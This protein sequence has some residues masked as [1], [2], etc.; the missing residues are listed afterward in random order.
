MNANLNVPLSSALFTVDSRDG[1]RTDPSTGFIVDAQN[2]Y[3][4]QIYKNQQLFSGAVQRI[5][6]TEINMPFNVPNVNPYNNVLY[7]E[8]G[9]GNEFALG[10]DV[11]TDELG[12]VVDTTIS[13]GFYTPQELAAQLQALLINSSA[14]GTNTWTVTYNASYGVPYNNPPGKPTFANIPFFTIN[15]NT[16]PF[17]VNPKFNQNKGSYKNVLI[18]PITTTRRSSTLAEM[19]GYSN[20]SKLFATSQVGNYAS[21]LYT[22]YIDIVSPFLSKHMEVRDTSSSYFNGSDIVAR[23]YISREGYD[24]T[25]TITSQLVEVPPVPPS[26]TPTY[27]WATTTTSNILGTRPFHLHYNFPVP[28]QIRWSPSEFLPSCNLRMQD[29]YGNV[30]YGIPTTANSSLTEQFAG[31][32]NWVEMNFLI[33]EIN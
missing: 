28:K 9:L 3:D 13:P 7:L 11:Y 26:T 1:I 2:P 25:Q 4:I 10:N 16:V 27:V 33:S 5:A 15:N 31:N 8:D 21:M 20:A 32:S 18:T 29:M 22:N 24:N 23:M 19:M 12:A 14:L 17:R 6:L 30:L